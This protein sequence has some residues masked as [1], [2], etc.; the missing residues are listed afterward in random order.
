MIFK[1]SLLL[2]CAALLVLVTN[3]Q[4]RMKT[5]E[6]EWKKIDSLIQKSGLTQSA[7][8]EVNQI[9]S[10]AKQEGNDA[11][12]I[13]ALLY[14]SELQQVREEDAFKKNIQQLETE[15]AASKDQVRAVLQSVTAQKYWNWFQLHRYQIYNRTKTVNFKKDDLATWGADDFHKKIGELYL[16][17][18]SNEKQLQQTKLEPFDPV[19]IKGNVR[20]LRPT[21]FDLLAHRALDYCKNSE[22]TITQPENAFEIDDTA[23][24]ATARTF[25]QHR[26]I[27]GDSLSLQFKALQL[28]QRLLQF[29]AGDAKPDA[30][31]DADLDRLQY[32]YNHA[33]MENKEV[34]Y[35]KALEQIGNNYGLIPAATQAWYLLAQWHAERARLYD[36]L[37]GET[38]RDEYQKAVNIID[39]VLV[40]KDS[41][42]GK[43]NCAN[44]MK[45]IT[46]SEMNLQSEK[47]NVPGQAFRTLISY[48]NFT[49]L[50]LRIVKM[51]AKTRE[52]LGTSNW[53]DSYWQNLVALPVLKSINQPLPAAKDYQKHSTEIKIEALPI[54]EYALVASGNDQFSLSDNQL[55]VQFFYVSNIAYINKDSEYFIVHRETGK[56]LANANVQVWYRSYDYNK[57]RYT[58]T[59]G[60][61]TVANGNG[62]VKINPPKNNN[63]NNFKL[64]ITSGNDHLMLDDYQYNY[65]YSGAANQSSNKDTKTT[66]LFTDRSIYRPGQ[67][68]YFKGIVVNRNTK[69]RE[70]TILP[71]YETSVELLDANG[72]MVD[73]ME[74]TTNEYGAYSGKFTLPT[75]LL[76]GEFRIADENGSDIRFSV[77]EYKRPK[78]LVEI[79]KPTGTY[80]LN[81][82][83]TVNGIAKAYAGNTIDGARVKYR[84]VR[85]TIMP[86]WFYGGGYRKM[87]WPPYGREETEIA[88]GELTTDAKGEF[89]ISF[90]AL[91]DN[92]I[93]KK[94]QP[95]FY[96]EVSADVT[97]IAGETRSGN[98]QVAVAYQA[99]QL[100]LMVPEKLHTDSLKHIM[101]QSTNLNEVFER[102]T[103]TLTVHKLQTPERLFRPRYWPQPDTFVLSQQEFY[104]AFPYDAYKDEDAPAKWTKAQKVAERTDTTSGN[105]PFT[106][107]HSPLTP[108]WY[109]IEAITKD[110]YGEEVK[111][112]KYVQLYNQGLVSPLAMGG[113]ESGKTTVEPGEKAV[114]QVS[115]TVEDAF[116]VH[117]LN[118]KDTTT[119]RSF[120]TLNRNSRSFEIPVTEKDRGGFG[121]QI[122]FVKH[123]R[124][125]TDEQTFVVPYT[126][127]ELTIAYETFRD[128]TL[129][130]S[131]EK[132][133]VRISGHKGDKVAAEMLTALYDASLDQF[134]PQKWNKPFL[135]DLYY[136]RQK[137]AGGNGFTA[138]QSLE[139]YN[140][141]QEYKPIYKEYD[142][143]NIAPGGGHFTI[144]RRR[145]PGIEAAAPAAVPQAANADLSEVVVVGYGTQ[146]RKSV[147]A[148][149]NEKEEEMPDVQETPAAPQAAVQVRKNFNET[150]FFLPDLHTDADGNIEF[151][152]TMPEAVTQWKWMSLV[153]SKDL[154]FG[155]D[156]KTIVTQKDLMVQPNA[157]RFLREGDRMNFSGKI[158]NL[159]DKEITGQVQLQ[160][161]DA[162]TNQAVDGWFRNVIPSQFFT[163]PAKQS[164]PVSFSIEIPYQY[165]KPVTYR[166]VAQ[167][168]NISDGEEAI[169]PVVSNRMLVTESL[170][171]PVRGNGTKNF[172]FEKLAKSSSSETLNHHALTVEF[173]TNPAWYAVQA[174]P[175]L[176]EYP[177]DCS[178]QVFNRYYANALAST[179]ANASPKIKQIFERWKTAD[180][181]ALLSN[182]QKNEELKS[183]LLQET[184]WVLQAKNEAQQ[185]KN[186]ALLFDLVRMSGE[187]TKNITKLQELQS[188]NGGFVWFKGGPDD[189]YMTQYILTGIGHLKKLK[190]LPSN[191]ILNDI[192]KKAIP[193]LDAR[194]QEDYENMLKHSK[195]LPEA[196][197]I[198]P[199][200]IQYLYMRSF[201]PE[202]GVPG[203][204]FKA[205]NYYRSQSQKAWVKQ[206][207]YMQGM[208]ALSLFRTGD[209]QTARNIV[210]SLKENA[211]TS[212]EMGLYWKDFSGGYYWY[213]S[214]V[215]SQALMIETFTEVTQD[216]AAVNEMKLWLLKQK[217]TRDWRTTKATAD[218]CYALLLQ[219]ADLL[220]NTPDVT[221]ELGN[222]A[223]R[224]QDQQQEAG[225]GY[226]KKVLDEKQV[227]PEMGNI[228]VTVSSMNNDNKAAAAWGAVYWQYFEDLNKI[229][230]AATPLQL[231]KKLFVEKNTER[232]PVL[233]PVNEGDVMKPGD[234]VKVRIE[235]RV[236][237]TMEYVHMKDMRAACLEPVNVISQYKWQGRLGYYES[238]KDAS[239]NFFFG[240]LPKG[241]YVF[242]YPLFVT[243]T[244]TFSNG[245][246]TIQCMYAPEFTSHSEGVTVKVE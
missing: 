11:Q 154:S 12:V 133:K 235:L 56:P 101:L 181:S 58:D 216:I 136:P 242:E 129:P 228:K 74:I 47:V 6:R 144:L 109:V 22:R 171:L 164:V 31:L 43:L 199:L 194:L 27:T 128:K 184:P 67:T 45:E 210:R 107:D 217:Q 149:S 134:K 7:L 100:K 176:M 211:L 49:R 119:E 15:I 37:K 13:K 198:S 209:V 68:V 17:S 165:N 121:I 233:Q 2:I 135:W 96:Y 215:E 131:E 92:T 78:F 94:G 203:N 191:D 104:A 189:R 146:K 201:F 50:H 175:Y 147:A 158:A 156:E 3:A 86:L 124:V 77:E 117:E 195:K 222:T 38:Y 127:K 105:K 207:K 76:N 20:H 219:G 51:D 93:A 9:Y 65:V 123:N 70:T 122:A 137:W 130:G 39:K 177:Y 172:S 193:Y 182:L 111:D 183:V 116:V 166:L 61:S 125:Y 53:E 35:T 30:L 115:T 221:I 206:S 237:R 23:A 170:P 142:Q 66:F 102:S 110:K 218:A 196:D 62:Y 204:V 161:I 192:I 208:I 82:N 69:T 48:R 188:S 95:T 40:Q 225:T 81:E 155:Y 25:M 141:I 153:H 236:D 213:Q 190:A 113:I 150:A 224:S 229:T 202:N 44:L 24:F 112:V 179:I 89:R 72:E 160:L 57:R 239:T 143:L 83:I 98:T 168:G 19:I 8:A 80:R 187:L 197:Y 97:D 21:L 178:E 99:L 106:I 118:R 226:F 41:S 159:T 26:F 162:A 79:N 238:T 120:F 169:L 4:Q 232:G 60:Q 231:T 36:P 163:V 244:G 138:V 145:V 152:F 46:R 16:A 139:K 212:E 108:G 220:S 241:T 33:T 157:P 54:G 52:S 180:S 88:H 18:I 200:H 28:Y 140:I 240:Q 63:E 103:V 243:H 87:I 214:P 174:L 230:P 1:R 186:I 10:L 132:W 5:Y 59:K 246:T 245:I 73:D 85:K 75:N 42:E 84:V 167:A 151:A 173:T 227:K 90:K 91:P 34:L 14:R 205:Y 55:A 234:K 29:H 126:N 223:V 185:K 32:V 114:Y 64:E 71:N 148:D